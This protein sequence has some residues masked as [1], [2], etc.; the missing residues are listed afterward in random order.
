MVYLSVD[1][2]SANLHNVCTSVGLV[3]HS[4][5]NISIVN[6]LNSEGLKVELNERRNGMAYGKGDTK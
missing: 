1:S 6:P 4:I 2:D 3:A 5:F